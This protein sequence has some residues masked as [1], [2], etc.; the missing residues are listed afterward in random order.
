MPDLLDRITL[1]LF[2]KIDLSPEEAAAYSDEVR[3]VIREELQRKLASLPIG[4]MI[5]KAIEKMTCEQARSEKSLG[6]KIAS[7]KSS[8]SSEVDKLKKSLE[9]LREKVRK[10][11]DN[12]KSEMRQPLYTFGGFSPQTNDLNI[13]PP[14]VEGAWRMVK[15]G[16]DLVF[17]R[18]ESGAWT[19]KG[20]FTP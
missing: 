19:L 6:E 3:D 12:L 18:Y 8:I 15:S 1:D 11:H 13:G 4:E 16:D 7:L 5:S 14:E 20:S 2:D 17:Q 10:N 9:E